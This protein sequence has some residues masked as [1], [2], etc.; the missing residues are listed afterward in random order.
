MI[1][2]N[3]PILQTGSGSAGREWTKRNSSTL[4][5]PWL[6][7]TRKIWLLLWYF[8]DSFKE[9]GKSH[10]LHFLEKKLYTYII[11]RVFQYMK[12]DFKIKLF[13]EYTTIDHRTNWLITMEDYLKEAPI[14][15]PK[16]K[17][18]WPVF[19]SHWSLLFKIKL[20]KSSLRK[21]TLI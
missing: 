20:F 12:Y 15:F 13:V 11:S 19:L 18:N 14:Y 2:Y 6:F 9:P 21:K 1:R 3:L 5:F 17:T 10:F 7:L 4:G 8:C 16:K